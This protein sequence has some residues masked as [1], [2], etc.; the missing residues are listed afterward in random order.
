MDDFYKCRE[1][2]LL[3]EM[4]KKKCDGRARDLGDAISFI[5]NKMFKR[6]IPRRRVTAA[7]STPSTRVPAGTPG[8]VGELLDKMRTP[9]IR[10]PHR[11]DWT[12][13]VDYEFIAAHMTEA[14]RTPWLQK[15]H[16]WFAARASAAGPRAR[17]AA[18]ERPP[19][20]RELICAMYAKW[21]RTEDGPTRPPITERVKVYRAAGVPETM[22]AKAVARDTWLKETW[23]ARTAALALV[24]AKW[25]AASKPTPK[26]KVKTKIIKAV[27]KKL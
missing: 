4:P 17:A 1:H 2:R 6:P 14:E 21:A 5:T 8:R 9:N 23:D 20:D 7:A 19:V 16:A 18:R 25:P 15:C 12:P 11:A 22:I 3:L 13:P 26:A 24:F 27:K 10:T